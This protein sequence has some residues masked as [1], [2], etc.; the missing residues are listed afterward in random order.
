[1]GELRAVGWLVGK[2]G[3]Q[4][5]AKSKSRGAMA[6]RGKKHCQGLECQPKVN[7]GLLKILSFIKNY[8]GF[9]HSTKIVK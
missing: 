9:C 1:M 4:K 5:K 8:S 6:E 3:L 2:G 7:W